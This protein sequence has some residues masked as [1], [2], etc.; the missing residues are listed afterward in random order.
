MKTN[1]SKAITHILRV[2][3]LSL[4]IGVGAAHGYDCIVDTDGDTVADGTAGATSNNAS[5]R[6]ACGNNASAAHNS[7]TA[8]GDTASASGISSTALGKNATADGGFSTALGRFADAESVGATA[9]GA[10]AT[11]TGAEATAVGRLAIA[12]GGSS[13]AVGKDASTD[14]ASN[15]AIALGTDAKVTSAEGG[16]AIGGDADDDG[17]GAT[18]TASGAIAIGADVVANK[19]NTMSIGVPVEVRR[20]DGTTQVKVNEKS[21]GNNVR[22]LFNLICDTCTPGFRFNQLLPSNN[23]WNFR[24]LQSG[25]FSVDDPASPSKEAEFRFGGVL[26]IAGNLIEGSSR[27]SKKNIEPVDPATILDQLA[28]LPIHHWSYN[29]H[30]DHVRHIGPMAEDFYRVFSL[31]ETDKGISGIDTAGIAL[32]AIKALKQENEQ[33]RADKDLQIAMLENRLQAQLDEIKQLL[34][35]LPNQIK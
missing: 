32:A 25:A 23:T 26:K 10:A 18:A 1:V 15:D 31:G 22:T 14:A 4:G 21:A 5:D 33:L 19:A 16:I 7:T 13:I 6:L 12:A 35:Q 17:E 3:L 30:P 34:A 20:N 24:M 2:S 28:N 27:E 9:L 29:H 8:I 11:A